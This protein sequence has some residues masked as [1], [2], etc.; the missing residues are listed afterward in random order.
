MPD[1]V[2][3]LSY[4]RYAYVEYNP[5]VFN[6]PSGHRKGTE[7]PGGGHVP[8]K[9]PTTPAPVLVTTPPSLYATGIELFSRISLPI[10]GA[11]PESYHAV[12]NTDCHGS[13]ADCFGDHGSKQFSPYVQIDPDEFQELLYAIKEDLDRVKRLPG[14]VARVTFDSPFYDGAPIDIFERQGNGRSYGNVVCF[15]E[16]CYHQSEVNYVAQGMYSAAAGETLEGALWVCN[17]WNYIANSHS[18]SEGERFWMAYGY[19][20]YL[21]THNSCSFAKVE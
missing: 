9:K 11:G 5:I 13:L 15:G 20:W 18:A 1:A 6:D 12:Y 7:G 14:D 19:H 16:D 2:S 10:L 8:G 4:D 21:Q 3:S 17:A